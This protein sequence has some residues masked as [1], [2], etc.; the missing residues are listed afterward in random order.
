MNIYQGHVVNIEDSK[1]RLVKCL[2]DYN[3]NEVVGRVAFSNIDIKVGDRVLVFAQGVYGMTES[4]VIPYET[5]NDQTLDSVKIFFEDNY[6]DINKDRIILQSFKD[7]SVYLDRKEINITKTK[8]DTN[9]M[10]GKYYNDNEQI[11]IYK[12]LD[13][14]VK[15]LLLLKN[16]LLY[17]GKMVNDPNNPPSYLVMEDDKVEIAHKNSIIN[18][19]EDTMYINGK[20]IHVPGLPRVDTQKSTGGFSQIMFCPFTGLPHNTDTIEG[21]AKLGVGPTG[22]AGGTPGGSTGT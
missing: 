18:M 2:L 19:T 16:D 3:K 20:D 4:I 9:N 7:S 6:I 17:L 1:N 22:V 14:V 13:N 15:A 10:Q 8:G 12:T 11:A 21:L 5:R